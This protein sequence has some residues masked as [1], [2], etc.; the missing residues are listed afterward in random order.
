MARFART[1][2]G[3]A[4]VAV[5][6][7]PAGCVVSDDPDPPPRR[8]AVVKAENLFISPADKQ[9]L[10]E[11]A[12]A[13]CEADEAGDCDAI[14]GPLPGTYFGRRGDRFWAIA[15]FRHPE[16]GVEGQPL[17]LSRRAGGAWEVRAQTGGTACDPLPEAMARIWDLKDAPSSQGS[18]CFRT[19]APQVDVGPSP[20][21]V[22]A[23]RKLTQDVVRGVDS[24]WAAALPEHF[25][26]EYS[27]PEVKGAYSSETDAPACGDAPAALNN[28]FYCIPG[29]YIAWDEPRLMFPFYN[30]FGDM[31]PAM[32]VAHEWGH[33]IQA[34]LGWE[35]P[36]SIYAELNAD[37]LAGAWA[38]A[39]PSLE[40]QGLRS[41]SLDE[42]VDPLFKFRDPAG[43]EWFDPG[44]HGSGL[45]R[46]AA[47]QYGTSG[48]VERCT[49]SDD[50]P[51]G[52]PG[53]PELDSSEGEPEAT[54]TAP[55]PPA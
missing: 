37:C 19:P 36:M 25:G 17:I 28:A 29:D 40:Q 21:V 54:E 8:V 32:V 46:I 31:A 48:D 12:V 7:G 16:H 11:S 50:L 20:E 26:T 42:V 49:P 24:Y 30:R 14:A 53:A 2:V 38:K 1:S 44:A 15:S 13:S 4:V 18:A 9:A 35:F 52:F 39:A 55:V 5:A 45:Q 10:R 34:R 43:S 41:T 23:Y 3:L 22:A 47:F 6:A 33:A 51:A 27:P